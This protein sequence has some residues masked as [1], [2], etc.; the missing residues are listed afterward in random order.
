MLI[1][2]CF[3]F[4]L[5]SLLFFRFDFM[6]ADDRAGNLSVFKRKLNIIHIKSFSSFTCYVVNFFL[7]LARV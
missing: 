4:F 6:L 1:D 3:S 5:L 2:L 7:N